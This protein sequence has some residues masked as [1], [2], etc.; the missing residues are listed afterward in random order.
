MSKWILDEVDEGIS[1][2][3]L[4]LD[5][6]KKRS[7]FLFGSILIL[8]AVSEFFYSLYWKAYGRRKWLKGRQ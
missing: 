2:L 7:I 1:L 5:N 4:W 3:D 6:S 8:F